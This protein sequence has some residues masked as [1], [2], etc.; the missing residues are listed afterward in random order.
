M[1][2]KILSIIL[3][4]IL[5]FSALTLSSCSGSGKNEDNT[6]ANASMVAPVTTQPSTTEKSTETTTKAPETTTKKPGYLAQDVIDILMSKKFYLTGKMR[7]ADGKESSVAMIVD[8]DNFRMNTTVNGYNMAV[9]MYNDKPYLANTKLNKIM[10]VDQ[11]AV[12]DITNQFSS[13]GIVTQ[14]MSNYNLDD[15]MSSVNT[16]ADI[17]AY[18]NMDNYSE[19]ESTF[20]GTKCIQSKYASEYGNMYVYSSGKNIIAIEFYDTDSTRQLVFYVTSFL[21]IIPDPVSIDSFT[22]ASSIINLFSAQ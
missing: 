7:S 17:T 5:S 1:S 13:L 18:L 22:T 12:D 20:D 4:A 10:L 11:Q 8:G 14:N 3:A 16:S 2:K 19:K 21:D 15:I 9:I 6:D